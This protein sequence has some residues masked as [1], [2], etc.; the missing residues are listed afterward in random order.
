VQFRGREGNHLELTPIGYQFPANTTDP[1][2][3]N[4][5]LVAV[6]VASPQGTWEVHDPCLTT[7]EA[8]SLAT[9]LLRATAIGTA[10]GP[11]TFSEPN[12]TMTARR[13]GVPGWFELA[14]EL[15]L[16]ARPPWAPMTDGGALRVDLTLEEADL[17]V[18]ARELVN[19]L[20]QYPQR[21]DNPTL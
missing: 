7:W 20:K 4:Q 2:D 15:E 17:L 19:E 3:S 6:R 16:E 9:W 21:G 13:A 1:W 18:A 14:V 8:R 10:F 11:S 12:V 5:L